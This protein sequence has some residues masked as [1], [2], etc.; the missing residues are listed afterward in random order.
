MISYCNVHCTEPTHWL[1]SG[2]ELVCLG[3]ESWVMIIYTLAQ[4]DN[5]MHF[6]AECCK[7]SLSL[8]TYNG[9]QM[10]HAGPVKFPIISNRNVL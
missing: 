5:F 10:Y 9:T 3:L 4:P 2:L 7:K 8:S 1:S 6:F